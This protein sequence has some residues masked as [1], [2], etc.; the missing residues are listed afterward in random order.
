MPGG[1]PVTAGVGGFGFLAVGRTTPL[2]KTSQADT[3]LIVSADEKGCHK[4]VTILTPERLAT[5][6]IGTK[7]F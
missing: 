5:A 3:G 1:G 7:S 4:S 2:S 6:R